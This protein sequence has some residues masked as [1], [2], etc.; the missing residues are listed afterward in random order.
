MRLFC[1]LLVGLFLIPIGWYHAPMNSHFGAFHGKVYDASWDETINGITVT[2][3]SLDHKQIVSNMTS[4][5]MGVGWPAGNFS[6]P[7]LKVGQYLLTIDSERY[8]HFEETVTCMARQ[9]TFLDITLMP[10]FVFGG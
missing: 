4:G 7:H 6:F 5:W 3:T 9:D 2:L 1:F 10:T 8:Q